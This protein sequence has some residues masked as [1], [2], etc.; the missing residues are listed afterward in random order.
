MFAE[1]YLT[2]RWQRQV[3]QNPKIAGCACHLFNERP[4]QKIEK[5]E[6]CIGRLEASV[7]HDVCCMKTQRVTLKTTPKKIVDKLGVEPRTARRQIAQ[8]R[9]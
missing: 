3:P 2:A 7:F 6:G 8:M 1:T 5:M 9:C 4:I